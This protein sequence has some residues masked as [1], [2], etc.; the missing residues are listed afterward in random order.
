MH[1]RLERCALPEIARVFNFGVTRRDPFKL[2]A[3]P[4]QPGY[5][6]AHRDNETPDERALRHRKVSDQPRSCSGS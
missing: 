5:F 4:G 6:R 2:L 1:E 3:Y